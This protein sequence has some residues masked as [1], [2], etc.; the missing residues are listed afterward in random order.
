MNAMTA[1]SASSAPAIPFW[2][3]LLSAELSAAYLGLSERTFLDR[4]SKHMLPAGR[5]IGARLLWHI[6][7]LDEYSDALFG[8]AEGE[9]GTEKDDPFGDI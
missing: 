8:L 3:R 7:I 1:V 9:G 6:K 5:K 2:P 4:V